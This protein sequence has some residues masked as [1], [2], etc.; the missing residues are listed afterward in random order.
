MQH[1]FVD[2]HLMNMNVG[3][4]QLARPTEL[5]SEVY[6]YFGKN[7]ISGFE[8][9][10]AYDKAKLSDAQIIEL[11][12]YVNQYI[13]LFEWHSYKEQFTSL[14]IGPLAQLRTLLAYYRRL[15]KLLAYQRLG[16]IELT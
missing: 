14:D 10:R 4:K 8:D 7:N 1:L 3:H 2:Q 12:S 15:R 5:Y 11:K 6:K 9:E 13:D 16:Q